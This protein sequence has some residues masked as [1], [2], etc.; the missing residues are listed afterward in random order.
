MVPRKIIDADGDGVEDNRA[1]SRRWLDRFEEDVYG[2]YIDDIHNTHNGE[3]AG[4]ERWGEDPEPKN[5]WNAFAPT[6]YAKFAP[7][8]KQGREA[9]S[10]ARP[11]PPED[12]AVQL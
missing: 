9:E 6:E 7:G 10:T 12:E 8:E 2:Y 4:H 3:L 5:V 11:G 1:V